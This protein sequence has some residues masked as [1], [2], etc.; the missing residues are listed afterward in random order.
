VSYEFLEHTADTGI[1]VHAESVAQLFCDAALG[2]FDL[3]YAL[4]GGATSRTVDVEASGAG[5]EELLVN[6]LA[7]LLFQ[8]EVADLAFCGFEVSHIDDTRVRATASAVPVAGLELDGPPIKA[9]TYHDLV[10]E[11]H[12]AGWRATVIFDV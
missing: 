1:E 10:V 4:V 9:V 6:W 2:M 7:E 8:S 3:T 12:P 5:Y 11:Q